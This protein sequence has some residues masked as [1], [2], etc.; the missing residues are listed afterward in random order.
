MRSRRSIADHEWCFSP[1]E[2]ELAVMPAHGIPG[3]SALKMRRL[4]FAVVRRYDEFPWVSSSA[5]F[6]AYHGLLV[7]CGSEMFHFNDGSPHSDC[8]PNPSFRLPRWL[9]DA[10]LMGAVAGLPV[11]ENYSLHP[12]HGSSL[13]SWPVASLEPPPPHSLFQSRFTAIDGSCLKKSRNRETHFGAGGVAGERGSLRISAGRAHTFTKQCGLHLLQLH[14]GENATEGGR[15]GG[16]DGGSLREGEGE[17]DA[18]IG[19]KPLAQDLTELA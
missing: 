19:E 14:R 13:P 1:A 6:S 7:L 12:L 18:V 9:V 11:P 16:G 10:H 15:G 5:L 8:V 17:T 3:H 4:M 2:P